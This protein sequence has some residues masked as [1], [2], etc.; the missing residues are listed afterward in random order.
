MKLIIGRTRFSIIIVIWMAFILA[1]CH[2]APTPAKPKEQ[3]GSLKTDKTGS[4]K[5]DK[6][7]SLKA[8][9]T[10]SLKA[11]NTTKRVVDEKSELIDDKSNPKS[12]LKTR[13]TPK[14]KPKTPLHVQLE[15][16]EDFRRKI[17]EPAVHGISTLTL[18][19]LA[20]RQNKESVKLS[21][22]AIEYLFGTI[23]KFQSLTDSAI[24]TFSRKG[25]E[26]W[27]EDL[28]HLS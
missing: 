24:G 6:I 17:V 2:G 25:F 12:E 15:K 3:S 26:D 13:I 11:D 21:E 22:N 23:D 7:G 5:A 16:A 28:A 19:L 20:G 18:S 9:K 10:G 14:P 8:D 4:L 1:F 27:K